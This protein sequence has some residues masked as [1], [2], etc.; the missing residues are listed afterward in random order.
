MTK[1][2]DGW[3]ETQYV[4]RTY[5]HASCTQKSFAESERELITLVVSRSCKG[6]E[7]VL[8]KDI[9][10]KRAQDTRIQETNK[11]QIKKLEGTNTSNKEVWNLNIVSSNLFVT[12]ILVSCNLF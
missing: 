11:R 12:C 9:I 1:S 6:P 5:P 3:A 8:K 7:R 10:V 4:Q 2:T